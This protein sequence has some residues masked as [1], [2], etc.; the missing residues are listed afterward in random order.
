MHLFFPRTPPALADASAF[1][2]P[3][4]YG[5]RD[6]PRAF[7]LQNL[8]SLVIAA[9]HS[10]DVDILSSFFFY[11]RK[12]PFFCDAVAAAFFPGRASFFSP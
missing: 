11:V 3:P 4:S 6:L 2:F 1:A 9:P 8:F 12:A 5:V 7:F 10:P